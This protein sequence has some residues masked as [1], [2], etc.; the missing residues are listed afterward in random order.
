MGA[1]TCGGRDGL[2]RA[3]APGAECRRGVANTAGGPVVN[4]LSVLAAYGHGYGG[5]GS[6]LAHAAVWSVVGRLLWHAPVVVA[7]LALVAGAAY[8]VMRGRRRAGD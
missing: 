4:G 8:L 6:T 5:L 2:V 1:G 7:L 3:H